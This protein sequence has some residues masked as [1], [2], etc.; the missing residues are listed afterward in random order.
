MVRRTRTM[1][2]IEY[3]IIGG[4][5][6]LCAASFFCVVVPR[7]VL[8]HVGFGKP[9]PLP[10][11]RVKT[12][13]MGL[14]DVVGVG[15]FFGMYAGGWLMM[16]HGPTETVDVTQVEPWVLLSELVLQVMMVGFVVLIL[17]WRANVI[18]LFGL[19]WRQWYL[20]PVFGVLVAFVMFSFNAVLAMAGYHE[21]M[22]ELAGGENPSQEAVKMIKENDDPVTLI[23]MTL[24]AC[25]GAPLAEEVVFRGYIYEVVK[26]LSNIGFSVVFSGLL[27]AAVHMNMAGMLPLF[28]LGVALALVYELTGSLWAPIAVH[29]V[30]NATSV[31]VMIAEKFHPE[32]FE[33]AARI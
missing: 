1:A 30:F 26:K 29:F 2:D 5:F 23:L 8:R 20:A 24:L 13:G 28:V 9:P 10:S 21:W 16:Q 25:V 11:G 3:W 7:Y 27:F 4:A 6:A 22:A 15:L 19:R 17:C 18:D 14:L 33:E 32:W 31:G 12:T